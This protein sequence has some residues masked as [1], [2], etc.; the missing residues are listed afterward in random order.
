[1][2][3]KGCL[4]VLDVFAVTLIGFGCALPGAGRYEALS[5]GDQGRM[6]QEFKKNWRDYDIYSDG[7]SGIT[8]AVIFDPKNDDKKLI[9]D[10]YIKLE[11]EKS[12]DL[13]ISTIRS[14][15]AF[16]PALYKITDDQGHFYGFVYMALYMPIAERIDERTLEL[17]HYVS[18]V[19]RGFR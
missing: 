9:G 11:D 16:Q 6:L 14:Y 17:P 7:P 10:G 15:S 8:A 4:A 13:A 18:P 12:V 19:H 1:V 5:W 2:K 3:P